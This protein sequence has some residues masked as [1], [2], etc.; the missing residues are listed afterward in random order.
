MPES[1]SKFFAYAGLGPE[2]FCVSGLFR[3]A[4]CIVFRDVVLNTRK[5]RFDVP[6]AVLPPN[7]DAVSSPAPVRHGDVGPGRREG[8]DGVALLSAWRL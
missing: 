8:D 4:K 5:V 6:A 1:K 7:S 3:S 2:R